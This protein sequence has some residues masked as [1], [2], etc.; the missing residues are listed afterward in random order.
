MKPP[1]PLVQSNL[2]AAPKLSTWYLGSKAPLQSQE[3]AALLTHVLAVLCRTSFSR[4]PG[5]SR[6]STG[7]RPM[8]DS[9]GPGMLATLISGVPADMG[10]PLGEPMRRST[11][12]IAHEHRSETRMSAGT[13][14]RRQSVSHLHSGLAAGL[15]Q[16]Q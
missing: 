4:V 12:S 10:Q 9:G 7:Y 11:K 1:L 5:G 15:W 8:A 3:L 6:R 16:A 14:A 2:T 13:P